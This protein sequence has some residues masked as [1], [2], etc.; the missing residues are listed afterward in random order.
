MERRSVP[1][2]DHFKYMRS[3]ADSQK[4]GFFDLITTVG[5]DLARICISEVPIM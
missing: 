3:T 1:L 2:I 5:A 4:R